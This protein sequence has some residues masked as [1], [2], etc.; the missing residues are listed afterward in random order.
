MVL[1]LAEGLPLTKDPTPGY[2]SGREKHVPAIQTW[3]EISALLL[4]LHSLYVEPPGAPLYSVVGA[5]SMT[6]GALVSRT[7]RIPVQSLGLFVLQSALVMTSA[8]S[9]GVH[10]EPVDVSRALGFGVIFMTLVASS[11]ML[12]RIS[13]Q[14]LLRTLLVV[15]VSTFV[16]QFILHYGLGYQFDPVA[17]LSSHRQSGWGNAFEHPYLGRLDRLG[18]LYNEPGTY[19]TFVAPLTLLY[20]L[21]ATTA[22][23]K[24]LAWISVMTLL[25][26]FSVYGLLFS[27]II[28]AVQVIQN[29]RRVGALG[30][31]LLI[32]SVV[33]GSLLV[34]PY[35]MF[36]FSD[37]RAAG[38][39]A[40]LGF[41]VD[42]I[43]SMLSDLE[44]SPY[45]LIIGRGLLT[46]QVPF[47][48]SG[49]INDVGL[50]FYVLWRSGIIGAS[51][52]V[53]SVAHLARRLGIGGIACV[54]MVTIS[55]MSPLM[56]ALWL[57]L[58]LISMY[59]CR[60]T[61]GDSCRPTELSWERRRWRSG[62]IGGGH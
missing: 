61:V 56:P 13:C 38:N 7:T 12:A 36:R 16:I 23:E 22:P 30:W 60:A 21:S 34:T 47:E 52:W 32:S 49:A 48:F 9:V 51:V 14:R 33:M 50:I 37:S 4:T 54:V 1:M 45:A 10:Q 3:T 59:P 31:I 24:L 62:G 5:L 55:K 20:S 25:A 2:L 57:I 19:A 58:A 8:L 53:A 18:G 43:R 41:R 40:G 17:L 28:L 46:S 15:H 44:E 35:L 42:I 29:R 11:A 6:F 26:S 27:L 39:D